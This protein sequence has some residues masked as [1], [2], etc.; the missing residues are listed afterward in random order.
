MNAKKEFLDEIRG[1]NLVCAKIGVDREDYGSH[2]KWSILTNK[3][4]KEDFDNFCSSIDYEYDAGYGSQ[5]LFGVI[6]FDDSYSE[7]E[8]YDGSEWWG[9]YK[10]PTIG[11]V[12]NYKYK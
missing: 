9:N 11:E 12:L 4:T 8:E 1:K 7:R 10:M 3:Y 5:E 2:I 6:L